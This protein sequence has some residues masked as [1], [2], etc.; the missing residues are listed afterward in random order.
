MQRY[1]KNITLQKY[2]KLFLGQITLFCK[3]KKLH[4]LCKVPNFAH[5]Q[6]Y[7]HMDNEAIKKKFYSERRKQGLSWADLAQKAGVSDYRKIANLLNSP[8]LTLATLARLADLVNLQPWQ[9]LK[10]DDDSSSDSPEQNQAP[11]VL[12]RC[13][14]CGA[15]LALSIQAATDPGPAGCPGP[16]DPG[17]DDNNSPK[18]PGALF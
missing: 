1:K 11:P 17:T 3:S 14:I 7:A 13:P 2:C 6:F 9:L 15:A 4:Y 10:P 8:G 16:G 12:A 5:S 18:D